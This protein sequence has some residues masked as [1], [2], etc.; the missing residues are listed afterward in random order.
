MVVLIMKK[1]VK[2]FDKQGIVMD[3]LPW[4]IIG[5]A[6]LAIIFIAMFLLKDK[7]I[8]FIDKILNLFR[9]S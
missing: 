4:L 3:Y 5:I 8:G 9:S 2:R 1:L 7:G 6:V